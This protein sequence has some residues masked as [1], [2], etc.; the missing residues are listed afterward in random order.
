MIARAAT[1]LPGAFLRTGPDVGCR[2]AMAAI[3]SCAPLTRSCRESRSTLHG[4]FADLTN[5]AVDNSRGKVQNA[6]A[7]SMAVR[8]IAAGIVS[9]QSDR[10]DIDYAPSKAPSAQQVNAS[11]PIDPAG[12]NVV[13]GNLG[14][15][16]SDFTNTFMNHMNLWMRAKKPGP[17]R[18]EW[19]LQA[20]A[21]GLYAVDALAVGKGSRLFLTCD[22]QEQDTVAELNAT[23]SF[24]WAR[25]SLGS[26]RL[27]TRY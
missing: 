8:L 23:A 25:V 18:I 22:G 6:V 21:D 7:D 20:P 15:C 16:Q 26:I 27:A 11:L 24:G 3:E 12:I 2:L 4:R 10:A 5:C 17:C 1:R 14:A 9:A 13:S 19:K